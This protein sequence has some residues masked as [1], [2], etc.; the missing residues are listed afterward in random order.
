[1]LKFT[2]DKKERLDKF[3]AGKVQVSRSQIQKAIKRGEVFVN[4]KV[5][6]ETDFE[7]SPHDQILSPDFPEDKLV[8]QNIDLDVVFEN[9]DFVVIN[10]PAGLTVHPGAGKKQGTLANILISKYPDIKNVGDPNRPGIVHR[11]DED[12]SGLM[13]IAKSQKAFDYAKKLFQTR[14]IEKEYIT[15]VHGEM[16]KL[17]DVI[18]KPLAKDSKRQRMKVGEGKEAV[19]EYTVIANDSSLQFSLLRVKLHTGRMHQ[20]RAHLA[21]IGHPVVG[22]KLYGGKIDLINRQFLHAF[23]LKFQL[24]DQTWIELQSDPPKELMEVLNKIGINYDNRI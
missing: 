3:L 24:P 2:A 17:H 5:V 13:L 6:T 9:E 22:D 12:T 10:K 18:D 4:D 23:R 14:N 21:S 8:P 15:L 20:I 19:T 1:M 11:L 16:E 7:V